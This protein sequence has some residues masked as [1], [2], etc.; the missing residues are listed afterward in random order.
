M[1]YFTIPRELLYLPLSRNRSLDD[2]GASDDDDVLAEGEGNMRCRRT[3]TAFLGN[4]QTTGNPNNV[5][6]SS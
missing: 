1:E 3:R 6:F 2:K 5:I 4:G